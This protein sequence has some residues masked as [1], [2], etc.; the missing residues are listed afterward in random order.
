MGR[1]FIRFSYFGTQYRG[2]QKNVFRN[3]GIQIH[4]TD[5]IQGAVEAAFLKLSPKCI[6]FPKMTSSSRTDVGVHSLC[7]SAHIDIE[8]KYNK[9]Y[10]PNQVLRV[11]NRYFRSCNHDIRLLEFIPV[12]ENFHARSLAKSRTYIYRIVKSKYND[13]HRLPLGEFK[14]SFQL[15][16]EN[17]DFE[18]MKR[19][20]QLFVGVK[21]FT[22]FSA[23]NVSE[24]PIRYVRNLNSL[25]I[26]N[27][28]PFMPHDPLSENY[29]YWH[30]ICSSRAFLY[31]Q[32]RRIVSTL[33]A[34][35]VGK[36][37]ERDINIMLQVP[38]H[39]NWL[40]QILTVPGF[41]L[42]LANVEYCQEELDQYIIKYKFSP[43]SELVDLIDVN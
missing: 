33:L 12:K 7:N 13:E 2:L 28:G 43:D 41:G 16:S 21:D 36:I 30:I 18:R 31:N 1:Y 11:V 3:E 34:L 17:F 26:E 32:V 5:T 37:T 15:K 29:E 10:N 25:T 9:I 19:A 39:H 4:D 35:G 38:G 27:V 22:T 14:H 23:R 42:Y 40:P 8:N 24:K 20:T 6:N